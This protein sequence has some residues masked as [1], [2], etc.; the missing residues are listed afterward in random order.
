MNWMY[1]SIYFSMYAIYFP[2]DIGALEYANTH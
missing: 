2:I 1:A